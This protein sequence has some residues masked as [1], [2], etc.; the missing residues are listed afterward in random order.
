[1]ICTFVNSNGQSGTNLAKK[2]MT[3]LGGELIPVSSA[4][5]VG[6]VPVD[7]HAEQQPDFSPDTHVLT[8]VNWPGYIHASALDDL[9]RPYVKNG[10]FGASHMFHTR[11]AD[12]FLSGLGMKVIVITREPRDWAYSCAR[13][14]AENPLP[15]GRPLDTTMRQHILDCILGF[16]PN[17]SVGRLPMVERYER[18]RLWT[19]NPEV[20]TIKF[21]DLIGRK[22]GG[23]D[24]VM[25][26]T[27][28]RIARFTETTIDSCVREKI[29][30]NLFG[31]TKTFRRGVIGTWREYEDLLEPYESLFAEAS[32]IAGYHVAVANDANRH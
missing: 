25:R 17:G 12:G 23:D 11:A 16:P 10:G 30:A 29:V 15:F 27:I 13:K 14:I 32:S 5:A 31:G 26:E 1:M 20:L 8:G 24:D 21:E 6:R 28:E 18:F 4:A 7:R 2:C 19:E 22:G 3:M 9:W